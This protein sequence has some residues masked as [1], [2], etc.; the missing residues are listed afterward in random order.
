LEEDKLRSFAI[1][2][3]A[4]IEPT[5]KSQPKVSISEEIPDQLDF[6]TVSTL[7]AELP[8]IE[9]ENSQAFDCKMV[10]EYRSL[11]A[12]DPSVSLAN[13]RELILK[14]GTNFE[15]MGKDILLEV[16]E[17][18]PLFYQFYQSLKIIEA[19]SVESYKYPK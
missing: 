7:Q 1:K 2:E 5:F 8:K 15:Q 9:T 12:D 10:R 11:H 6:S 19:Q 16:G 3:A 13:N 14:I 18:D 4:K 17:K